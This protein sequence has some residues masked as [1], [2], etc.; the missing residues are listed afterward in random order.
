MFNFKKQVIAQLIISHKFGSNKVRIVRFILSG[1]RW[2]AFFTD[3]TTCV[4][5]KCA[6]VKVF[7]SY[8]FELSEE[9]QLF[10]DE[11]LT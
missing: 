5:R 11:L 10:Q 9:I 7:L 8:E 3:D 6:I 2:E 4:S 1:I